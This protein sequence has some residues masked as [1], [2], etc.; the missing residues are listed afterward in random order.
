[1]TVG[2]PNLLA[3]AMRC[4]LLTP[5]AIKSRLRSATL[6]TCTR[7]SI[8]TRLCI[9]SH[10]SVPVHEHNEY[11]RKYVRQETVETPLHLA[12]PYNL[13]ARILPC[14]ESPSVDRESRE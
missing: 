2:P 8:L 5:R 3:P 12:N 6:P 1:M 9:A 11:A 14:P 4:V 13:R 7:H 10:Q